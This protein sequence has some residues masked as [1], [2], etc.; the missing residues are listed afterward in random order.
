MKKNL[1]YGTLLL[2]CNYLNA[3]TDNPEPKKKLTHVMSAEERVVF[4]QMQ[5][6]NTFKTSAAPQAP[7]RNIAEFEPN[8]AAIISYSG[9]FGIPTSLI[10]DLSNDTKL[11]VITSSSDKPSCQSTLQA[12]SGINMSNIQYLVASVDSYWARD[13]TGW[14]IAD[15]NNKVGIVDFQYNRPRPNDDAIPTKQANLLNITSYALPVVHTG[16]NWMCDGM[17]V[18][19]CTDLV[20]DENS[21]SHAQIDQYVKDYLGIN[22]HL[23]INDPQ[24]QYIKH[25]DCFG[26]FLAVDKVLIDSVP[27]SDPRFSQYQA[28]AAYYANTNCS[29]GY[30]YK[31]YRPFTAGSANGEPYSNSFICNNKV[32]LAFKGTTHDTPALNLYKSAMPGY[33]VTGYIGASATPWEPTDALHCRVHEIADRA[34]LYINHMP[35]YGK[36]CSNSGYA[37]SANALSYAGT[38]LKAGYPKV[39]YRINSGV[40]D[41]LAM[42]LSSGI[43]YQAIIPAQTTN[44]TKIEYYIKAIDANNKVANHPF[45]GAPDPHKFIAECTV[46]VEEP[47]TYG[48][49]L[50]TYPIPSNGN[51]YIYIDSRFNCTATVKISNMLG[52]SVYNEMYHVTNGVNM[53]NINISGANPGIYFVEF[54]SE[55]ETITKRIVIE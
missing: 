25:M 50:N 32:Y 37:I 21:I 12:I 14:F 31:I 7:V 48:T 36:V 8:E 19:T 16:G 35:L 23:V 27:T 11:I 53:S 24:G 5:M 46:G 38:A 54:K 34:M 28:T 49:Y 43:T 29:Y 40:W 17:G 52:Q 20:W 4:S 39:M 55:R 45:I 13:Y 9:E 10:R 18:G 15:G 26:K 41:S 51:F 22:R 6:N 30:K 42:T 44:G 47:I 3:Q 2:T 1:L 33:T